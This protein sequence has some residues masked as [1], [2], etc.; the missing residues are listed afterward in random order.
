MKNHL[1]LY[2]RI[3]VLLAVFLSFH[4]AANAQVKRDTSIRVFKSQTSLR[5]TMPMR[6]KRDTSIALTKVVADPAAKGQKKVVLLVKP[7][8][9]L[10]AFDYVD[11]S[12][13]PLK[14]QE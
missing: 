12:L 8:D 13:L 14:N 10:R 2:Q 11:P 7:K 9:T 1:K 6:F 5:R 3:L 4:C